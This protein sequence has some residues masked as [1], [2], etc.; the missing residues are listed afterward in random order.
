M[1]INKYSFLHT[2]SHPTMQTK[3]V[4]KGEGNQRKERK[5]EITFANAYM[6]LVDLVLCELEQV[7]EGIKRIE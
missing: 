7:Y 5:E 3:K 1:H 6:D 4:K 2:T